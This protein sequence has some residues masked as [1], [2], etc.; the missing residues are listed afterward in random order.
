MYF[1]IYVKGKY[2]DLKIIFSVYLNKGISCIYVEVKEENVLW[3]KYF[4]IVYF[5][6]FGNIFFNIYKEGNELVLYF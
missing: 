3:K 2:F 1:L 4:G 5:F 6:F